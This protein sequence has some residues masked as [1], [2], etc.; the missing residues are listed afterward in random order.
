MISISCLP[1]GLLGDGPPR[2]SHYEALI[3]RPHSNSSVVVRFTGMASGIGQSPQA[4]S[5]VPR[6]LGGS[7]MLQSPFAR[8]LS[9]QLGVLSS[10][11]G[12]VCPGLWPTWEELSPG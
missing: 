8:C 7:S 10:T 2:P 6:H 9:L 1:R 4:A 12:C 5:S 3:T 11:F